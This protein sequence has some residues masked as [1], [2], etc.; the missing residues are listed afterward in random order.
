MD[1]LPDSLRDRIGRGVI[2]TFKWTVG[3]LFRK[4]FRRWGI[5]SVY[6][7]DGGEVAYSPQWI[8][9]RG[10]PDFEF[11]RDWPIGCA[12]WLVQG[13]LRFSSIEWKSN[14]PSSGC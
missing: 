12:G 5:E 6:R 2:R 8:M 1:L 14:D 4:P 13:D 3:F 9:G 10:I 7:E 11:D